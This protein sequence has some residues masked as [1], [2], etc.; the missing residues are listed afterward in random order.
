MEEF[1]SGQRGQTVNLLSLTSMVR[2]HPPPPQK[3]LAMQG[4]FAM[5][6]DVGSAGFSKGENMSSF[7]P[8]GGVTGH[9]TG[10]N[11]FFIHEIRGEVRR[12]FGEKH[13]WEMDASK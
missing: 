4:F 3:S 8:Y 6:E 1:P 12:I 5:E 2:I 13:N 7:C 9:Y 10:V 11:M